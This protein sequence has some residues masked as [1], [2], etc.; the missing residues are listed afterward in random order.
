MPTSRSRA[1]TR[2]HRRLAEVTVAV[3]RAR[4]AAPQ[5]AHHSVSRGGGVVAA[6]ELGERP[7]HRCGGQQSVD[8]VEFGERSPSLAVVDPVGGQDRGVLVSV[9]AALAGAVTGR[10]DERGVAHQ[11]PL[12]RLVVV[13]QS[14]VGGNELVDRDPVVA[15]VVGD[16]ADEVPQRHRLGMDREVFRRGRGEIEGATQPLAELLVVAAL[17][18]AVA[19]EVEAV[20]QVGEFSSAELAEHR[21]HSL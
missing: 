20:E 10:D 7:L 16:R 15:V 3:E 9:E 13:G 19:V 2:P 21:W 18:H 6:K 17:E 1:R 14:G 4:R 11:Q 8:D 5:A 12:E